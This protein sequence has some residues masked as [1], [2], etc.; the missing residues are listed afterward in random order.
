MCCFCGFKGLDPVHVCLTAPLIYPR[1]ILDQSFH[2]IPVHSSWSIYERQIQAAHIALSYLSYCESQARESHETSIYQD[3]HI[4]SLSSA[5]TVQSFSLRGRFGLK[6]NVHSI[7][8]YVEYYTFMFAEYRLYVLSVAQ[9]VWE[10]LLLFCFVFCSLWGVV[11]IINVWV[12]SIRKA[13]IDSL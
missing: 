12:I 6:W 5:K 10:K 4:F 13:P 9:K 7:L 3:G 2:F 8:M 11:S 1:F